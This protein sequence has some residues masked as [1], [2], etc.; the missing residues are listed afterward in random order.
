MGLNFDPRLL[1]L[2]GLL[3]PPKCE[4]LYLVEIID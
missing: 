1:R 3:N 4:L 2:S